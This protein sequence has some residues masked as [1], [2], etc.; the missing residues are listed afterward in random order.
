[1]CGCC[2]AAWGQKSEFCGGL[3]RSNA[4]ARERFPQAVAAPPRVHREGATVRELRVLR[5]RRRCP[6]GGI[7]ARDPS[8]GSGQTA[9]QGAQQ[10]A[11]DTIPA[12]FRGWLGRVTV[13]KT[14]PE[15]R[16]FVETFSSLAG[17][18]PKLAI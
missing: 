17:V 15:I 1:M 5:E 9:G 16:K 12:E 7:P 14:V 3:S 2:E 13:A 6:D 4:L 18:V 10:P 8:T 11:A